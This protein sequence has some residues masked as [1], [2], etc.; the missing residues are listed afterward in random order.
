RDGRSRPLDRLMDFVDGLGW[1][2]VAAAAVAVLAL[3]GLALWLV[4]GRAPTR[5]APAPVQ[6]AA[7]AET[8]AAPAPAPAPEA[9]PAQAAPATAPPPAATAT[10]GDLALETLVLFDGR[11]PSVFQSAP[12]NPVSF[13]GDADGGFARIASSTV[14]TG[15]RIAVGRGVYER[16]AGHRIRLVLVVRAA[17]TAPATGLRFAY[18]NGPVQSPWTDVPITASYAPLS[19]VWTAPKERGGPENDAVIIEPGLPGDGTAIDVRS[20]RIEILG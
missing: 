5:V 14:S 17:R 7:P 16:I 13:Q 12:D 6:Q 2:S 20:V 1:R 15:A 3:G 4:S 10:A 9:E 19:F 8:A 11:D 18:Q